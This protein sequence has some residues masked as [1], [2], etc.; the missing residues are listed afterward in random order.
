MPS[1]TQQTATKAQH[2]GKQE[3]PSDTSVASETSPDGDKAI[4]TYTETE[5]GQMRSKMQLEIN[6]AK[7]ELRE[8][9]AAHMTL[10]ED[11]ETAQKRS[12]TLEEE[13]NEAYTDESLR[14]A[15]LKHRKDKLDWNN[16]QS[17]FTREKEEF[18]RIAKETAKKDQDKLAERLAKQFGVDVNA[19]L[20]FDTPEKMKAYALDNFDASKV[21]KGEVVEV[22][23]LEK[24]VIPTGTQGGGGNWRDL[25]PEDRVTR[26][27]EQKKKAK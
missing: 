6:E 20:D 22:E 10:Q 17:T 7:K 27:L 15:V 3:T 19:L 13:A 9:K 21:V 2:D 8:I 24:P 18:D 4:R 16:I 25:T 12:T 26:G 5:Y 23:K 11:L 1:N 14:A